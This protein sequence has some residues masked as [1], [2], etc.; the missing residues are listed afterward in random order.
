LSLCFVGLGFR[1]GFSQKSGDPPTLD[2][3]LPLHRQLPKFKCADV[4]DRLP[5]WIY[6]A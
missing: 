5:I 1:L 3:A 6:L 2:I 4:E